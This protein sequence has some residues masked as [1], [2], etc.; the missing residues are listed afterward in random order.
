MSAEDDFSNINTEPWKI[1]LEDRTSYLRDAINT[2]F[3]ISVIMYSQADTSTFRYRG[4]NMYQVLKNSEKWKAV[5]FFEAELDTVKL[6]FN[7]IDILIICRMQWSNKLQCFIDTAKI[8]NIPVIFD[9]DDRVFDLNY[10]PILCNTLSLTE[11]QI[12][13]SFFQYISRIEM[14][15]R[16]CE[17]YIATN[18]FLRDAFEERFQQ[19]SYII[20]NFL[21]E[22]QL[23]ISE[24]CCKKKRTQKNEFVIGYFSGSP[25]H[26][27]DFRVV[28]SQIQNLMDEFPDI[29][30][31]VVGFME[32]PSTMNKFITEGRIRFSPLVDFLELQKLIAN[33]DIN[34]APLVVNDFTNCKS[35][36]KFFE[37]AI[38]DTVTV[39]SDIFTFKNC[40]RNGEN[41]FICKPTEWHEV[42]RN[43]YLGKYDLQS[44]VKTAHYDAI[45]KYSGESIM[46]Q[47]ETV[48]DTILADTEK[49]ANLHGST[50]RDKRESH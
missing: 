44:I 38:V 29:I 21:D 20:P 17:K 25:T 4:Y 40:I 50:I 24:K 15:A 8:Q 27:N 23:K 32:F 16:Q 48:Y 7:E 9:C 42:L 13:E 18:G 26:I 36:L 43:I 31:Q 49:T 45:K 41:G 14:T 2:G 19:K 28:S 39:T 6:F 35:E 10:L 22:E 46:H 30:L 11:T 47:I 33:V 5:Y 3:N 34:I 1:S 12:N 37:A